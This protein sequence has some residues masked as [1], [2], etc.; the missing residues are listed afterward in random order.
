MLSFL[1]IVTTNTFI[2][3]YLE[4]FLLTEHEK[5]LLPQHFIGFKVKPQNHLEITS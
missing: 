3:M 2:F 1:E 4:S 5:I